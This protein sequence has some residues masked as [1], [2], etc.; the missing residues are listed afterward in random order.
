MTTQT[1]VSLIGEMLGRRPDAP[2]YLTDLL[3][4]TAE[5]LMTE[6][7]QHCEDHW[8]GNAVELRSAI[9]ALGHE[10]RNLIG[11]IRQDEIEYNELE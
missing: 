7:G 8:T 5:T 11:T 9:D 1:H 2:A 4:D 6:L 3:T 10:L